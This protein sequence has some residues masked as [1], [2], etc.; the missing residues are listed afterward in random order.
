MKIP[1]EALTLHIYHYEEVVCAFKWA[2]I[3]HNCRE[4]VFWGL[5]LYDSGMMD[6]IFEVLLYLWIE[7]MGFGK[8][9]LTTL[10][11]IL[12]CQQSDELDRDTWI[13][14]VYMWSNLRTMD[15]TGFQ[16]LVRGALISKISSIIPLSYSSRP[17]NTASLQLCVI[18][19]H[20]N[21][22]TTSS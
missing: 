16:I 8:H 6:D 21:A 14:H 20:L 12:G 19:A 2:I 4:A 3:T 13:Q 10:Y 7:H 18:I 5:E 22:H 9:C 1:K 11:D 17:Q 15:S